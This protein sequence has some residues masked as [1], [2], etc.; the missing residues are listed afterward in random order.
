MALP[1]VRFIIG[2]GGLGTPAPGQDYV[3]G[4]LVYNNSLPS[5]FSSVKRVIQ[6]FSIEDAENAGI[7]TDNED[8]VA[9]TGGGYT[10]TAIGVDG[11]T[12]ANTFEMPDGSILDLGT[13]TKVI[14]DSTVTLVAVGIAAA[15]NAGTATHGWTAA[16]VG[17]ALT[18]TSTKALGAFPN[19][20]T[21]TAT[22]DGTITKGTVTNFA[23]GVGSKLAA[24]HYHI[25]EFFR[26]NPTGNIYFGIYAVP[27]GTYDFAE[28]KTIQD[29][30][31]G[32][33]RQIGIYTPEVALTDAR[34]TAIQTILTTT[35]TA[36]APLVAI[37]AAD[38][39]AVTDLGTLSNKALLTAK[40]VT[41]DIGQ[42]GGNDGND[43]WLITEKSITTIGALLGS[44]SSAGVGQSVA[45]PE[46]FPLVTGEELDVAAFANGT[47]YRSVSDNL[48]TQ[49]D[50]YKYVFLR[51]Y[52]GVN[53]TFYVRDSTC[54]ANTS[55]Y[56]RIRLSRTIQKM[57]RL[58]YTAV[59][60]K[61]FKKLLVN[62]DGTLG[63]DTID[64][65]ITLS[66]GSLDVMINDQDISQRRILI[67][68]SQDVLG[69]NELVIT[70]E[71]I[72]VG[73]AEAIKVNIG[74]VKAF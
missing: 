22:I 57:C 31:N 70:A 11:D 32:T 28:V 29:F 53:G 44:V 58:I 56:S 3:S 50:N 34:V 51:K 64:E 48:L 66:E 27:G 47:L 13:Y 43:L 16:N 5:G 49:L 65:F 45:S 9:A 72:P 23:S 17:A 36:H 37:Y 35:E 7:V 74:F 26:L 52:N 41:V 61:L 19:T 62:T 73:S 25:S 8:G 20:L 12:I 55:D 30:S 54:I 40:Y 63:Q 38:I 33:I 4:F 67:N 1:D 69:T 71:A 2:Q 21:V 15:T 68:A 24:Y 46:L 39:S 18:W 42:D 59:V 10:V 60:P 14:G 6:F